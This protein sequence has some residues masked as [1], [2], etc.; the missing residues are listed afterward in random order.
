[1]QHQ[2]VL[3]CLRGK[4]DSS[5]IFS[6]QNKSRQPAS[7]TIYVLKSRNAVHVRKPNDPW[8]LSL[9][10]RVAFGITSG[11]DWKRVDIMIQVGKLKFHVKLADS[12]FIIIQHWRWTWFLYLISDLH[13][14]LQLFR[15]EIPTSIIKFRKFSDGAS[16]NIFHRSDGYCKLQHPGSIWNEVELCQ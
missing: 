5:I 1:M 4:H 13:K 3:S 7:S 15:H 11:F 10:M 6:W 8:Q 2:S 9:Q 14:I 12:S 16:W